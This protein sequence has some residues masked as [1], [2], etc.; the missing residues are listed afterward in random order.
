MGSPTNPDL[1]PVVYLRGAHATT[2]TWRRVQTAMWAAGWHTVRSRA[3]A[4][5][6]ARGGATVILLDFSGFDAGR[7][8]TVGRVHA[9]GTGQEMD[10]PM[11]TGLGIEQEVVE[12]VRAL[13]A[14]DTKSV[15]S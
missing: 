9:R 5:H 13:W 12:R 4:W 1:R 2:S 14:A 15:T 3:D 8:V 11:T 7:P 10:L 6:L